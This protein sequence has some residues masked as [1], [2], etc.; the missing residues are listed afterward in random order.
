MLLRLVPGRSDAG[1]EE[2]SEMSQL[3]VGVP[4]PWQDEREIIKAV[5]GAGQEGQPPRFIAAGGVILEVATNRPFGFDIYDHDAALVEAF[6][7]AGQG[8]ISE[9]ELD[10]IDH[11]KRTVYIVCGEPFAEPS[12]QG[13]EAGRAL[14]DLGVHMLDAGGFAVKVEHSGIAHTPERWR[15]YARQ[16]TTLSLYDAFVTMVGSEEY[17]YTCGMHTFGLPDVSLTSGI[18]PEEA[19]YT[20]NGFNQHHLLESPTLSE[21]ASFETSEVAPTLVMS[22]RAYGYEDG[23]IQNNPHGRW[24]LEIY[25]EPTP[26]KDVSFRPG[27]KPLFM[28]MARDDPALLQSIEQA[29]SSLQRFIDHFHSPFEYGNYLVKTRINDGDDT[30]YFWASLIDADEQGLRVE[31]IEVP[32]EFPSYS[33]GQELLL[34]KEDIYDWSINRNGTLIGG[35]SRRIAREHVRLEERQQ[36]DLYSGDIAFAPLEEY[37]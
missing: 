7:H 16:G 4:G 36:F 6:T 17:S 33:A 9:D 18:P 8:R 28:A 21:G 1:Q 22:H 34:Q 24:H 26:P 11:H 37:I 35:F 30:A 27:G 13:L 23:D 12:R 5:A 14:M 3:V 10:L 32:P 29:R 15:Y 25:D 31:L 2:I 20:L 19:P